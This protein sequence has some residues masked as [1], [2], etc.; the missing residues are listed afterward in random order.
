MLGTDDIAGLNVPVGRAGMPNEDA[1]GMKEK[2]VADGVKVL[3][4]GVGVLS[5]L[6]SKPK[7]FPCG[8]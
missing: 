2:S 1:V 4:E 5:A 6:R 8:Y 3:W 7:Y